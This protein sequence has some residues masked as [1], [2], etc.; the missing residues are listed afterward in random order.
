MSHPTQ[1]ASEERS[2]EPL[3]RLSALGSP[4]SALPWLFSAPVDLAVFLGSALVSLA[5]LGAGWKLGILQQDTPG[6]AWVSTILLIDVAHVYATGF[7]VYFDREELARRPGL[8]FGVPVMGFLFGAGLYSLGSGVFWRVLAYLA[9]FHFVRQQYGWVALYRAKAREQELWSRR[10]D[11][12]AIYLATIYPL[13]YWHGHLPRGFQW[14]LPEDFLPGLPGTLAA[15]LAP[16]YWTVLALYFLNAARLWRSGRANPGKDI[17]V[18]TTAICWYVG[19]ITFNSDYAFTVTNVIIHGVPYMALVYWFWRTRK[20]NGRPAR[21]PA[22]RML[23]VFLGTIWLLAYIEELMWDRTV[24]QERDWL[25][26]SLFSSERW[27]SWLVPL[28]AV[29][30]LT[31]YVLDGFIWKRRKNPDLAQ[32]TES[33]SGHSSD[34]GVD[35]APGHFGERRTP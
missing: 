11:T 15:I 20:P 26:G 24:W 33:P 21:Q 22:W 18:A 10:L 7:R 23:V 32:F 8:Y 6:W 27:K 14:F 17:V 5:L 29:P 16:V 34:E 25:F 35:P 1:L 3:V 13:I 19:I 2:G 28:L 31:H 30:Q 4:P 9:V 12:A